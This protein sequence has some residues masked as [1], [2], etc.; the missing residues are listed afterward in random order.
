MSPFLKNHLLFEGVRYSEVSI[1][2]GFTEYELIQLLLLYI[3]M[4]DN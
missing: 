2:G 1:K 4:L 3:Q